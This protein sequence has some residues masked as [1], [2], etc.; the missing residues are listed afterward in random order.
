[1]PDDVYV[2]DAN[3]FIEAMNRYYAFD[4]VPAFWDSL[5]DHANSGQIRSIDRVQSEC[6]RMKNELADWVDE[7]FNHAFDST[8]ESEIVQT[9]G[10]VINWVNEQTQFSD[11]A[12]ADFA[13]GA[14]GWLIAYGIVK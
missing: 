3:V 14:D 8:D 10:E 4:L 12:K 7:D 1:M 6:S 9:F 11:A 13:G 2:L 5:I